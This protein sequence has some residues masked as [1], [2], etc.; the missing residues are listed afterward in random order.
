MGAK[1]DDE[2]IDL[3]RQVRHRLKEER[4]RARHSQSSAARK[5]GVG[6]STISRME[7]TEDLEHPKQ[8]TARR[9]DFKRLARLYGCSADYLMGKSTQRLDSSA[10]A[11]QS[12]IVGKSN[13]ASNTAEPAGGSTKKLSRAKRRS[14]AWRQAALSEL[15]KDYYDKR[16]FEK[17]FAEA[18]GLS[19]TGP[20]L[21][22][23]MSEEGGFLI[24][25]VKGL[26]DKISSPPFVDDEDQKDR[27]VKVLMHDPDSK[28]VC[29]MAMI[30]DEGPGHGVLRNYRQLVRTNLSIFC[31]LRAGYGDK[32]KIR[33]MNYM[34]AFGLDLF[35][36]ANKNAGT[37]YVRYYPLPDPYETYKDKPVVRLVQPDGYWFTEAKKQFDRHW[38]G[39]GKDLPK[40]Y[41][42]RPTIEKVWETLSTE[43]QKLLEDVLSRQK[44]DRLR[45][46]R[47]EA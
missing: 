41:P 2:P 39:V 43:L 12:L 47:D 7:S 36:Y 8:T 10:E 16:D 3:T 15:F 45:G 24:H 40:R 28:V 27:D 26:L 25:Q 30:Q 17:D 29:A 34:P 19:I 18:I 32:V 23:F 21:R 5:S 46:K 13:S 6:Q 33:T 9:K 20:N 42:W 35:R 14:M 44:Q 22:R 1:P 31:L 38:F 4:E 37:C 11:G